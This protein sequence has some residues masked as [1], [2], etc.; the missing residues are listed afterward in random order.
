MRSFCTRR[1][2]GIA[3]LRMRRVWQRRIAILSIQA[4]RSV[5]VEAGLFA[6]VESLTEAGPVLDAVE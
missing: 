3:G 4:V 1:R 2:Q 6:T 5:R